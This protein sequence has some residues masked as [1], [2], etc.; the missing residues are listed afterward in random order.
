MKIACIGWGS[1]VWRPES[2]L[3][4]RQW[5]NDGPFL[6]V[7]YCRK[8]NDGRLTL[9]LCKKT[10][11]IRT[12][13]ALM[14][15]DDLVKAKKSLQI[16][17]GIIDKYADTYIS[18]ISMDEK[19]KDENKLEIQQWMKS[20]NIDVSIWTSLPPKFKKTNGQQHTDQ[21]TLENAI[22]YL[23]EQDINVFELAKEY[24]IRTPKQVDTEFRRAFEKEFGWT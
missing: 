22:T 23:K 19:T 24:V 6:P 13:W 15:T 5:F 3:I 12:L 17:E 2:L 14:A 8:S 18:S 10:K 7:E 20:L 16:R 4:H 21:P 11:P 9:V 1:L